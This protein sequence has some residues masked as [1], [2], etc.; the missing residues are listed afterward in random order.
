MAHSQIP[1]PSCIR[2]PIRFG[3]RPTNGGTHRARASR[4]TSI[5]RASAVPVP[6]RRSS[7]STAIHTAHC[8]ACEIGHG[9][10]A[11]TPARRIS[12]RIDAPI[13]LTGDCGTNCPGTT[14]SRRPRLRPFAIRRHRCT[15]AAFRPGL[16]CHSCPA[17]GAGAGLHAN[18]AGRRACKDRRDPARAQLRAPH[19]FAVLVRPVDAEDPLRKLD[20]ECLNR[21]ASRPAPVPVDPATAPPT[22]G[23]I[24]PRSRDRTRTRRRRRRTGSSPCAARA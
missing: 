3:R 15:R 9:T 11:T 16:S 18:R 21:A 1:M 23:A 13:A 10:S 17:M 7:G 6:A 24:P 8:G 22:S 20:A 2:I 12:I 19:G 5:T 4:N 14:T